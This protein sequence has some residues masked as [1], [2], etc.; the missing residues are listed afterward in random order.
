MCAALADIH[1]NFFVVETRKLFSWVS[2]V[3]DGSLLLFL[4]FTVLKYRIF[5]LNDLNIFHF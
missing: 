1:Y 3:N 4:F 5:L 2:L